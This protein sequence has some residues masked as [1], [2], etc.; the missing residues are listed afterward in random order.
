MACSANRKIEK[1]LVDG[2]V[3]QSCVQLVQSVAVYL[4]QA[5]ILLFADIALVPDQLNP[6]IWT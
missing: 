2:C 4:Q 1:S 3:I 5:V 6:G